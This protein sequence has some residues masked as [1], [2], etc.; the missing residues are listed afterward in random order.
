MENWVNDPHLS[1]NE[2]NLQNL[3]LKGNIQ[4][5]AYLVTFL[6][7]SKEFLMLRLCK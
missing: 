7:V 1:I 3:G 4:I 5:E 6:S 2:K